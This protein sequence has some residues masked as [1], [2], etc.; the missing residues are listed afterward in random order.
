[1]GAWLTTVTCVHASRLSAHKQWMQPGSHR[2]TIEV[3]VA[4]AV[5]KMLSAALSELASNTS[6]P[7]TRKL[8]AVVAPAPEN[9]GASCN[10]VGEPARPTFVSLKNA[11]SVT[12]EN[13]DA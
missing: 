4:D 9:A 8:D 3:S 10:R 12:I 1:M 11:T 5:R 13:G 2:P 6:V 7:L